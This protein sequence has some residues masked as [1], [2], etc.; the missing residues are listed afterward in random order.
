MMVLFIK[1]FPVPAGRTRRARNQWSQGKAEP[2]T[3]TTRKWFEVLNT[4]ACVLGWQRGTWRGWGQRRQRGFRTARPK[5]Q[6]G[7][8]KIKNVTNGWIDRLSFSN[9]FLFFNRVMTE[10]EVYLETEGGRVR[11]CCDF[12][13]TS[14]SFRYPDYRYYY[15][16][17]CM[18]VF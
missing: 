5:G 17:T 13:F 8:L 2:H 1:P 6:S 12:N 9:L 3:N 4:T 15:I 18:F 10:N 16:L 14:L 7:T 11:R